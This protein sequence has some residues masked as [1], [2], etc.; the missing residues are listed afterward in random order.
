LSAEVAAKLAHI[1]GRMLDLKR[2]LHSAKSCCVKE[3]TSR[4]GLQLREAQKKFA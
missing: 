1:D 4:F 3:L 2:E